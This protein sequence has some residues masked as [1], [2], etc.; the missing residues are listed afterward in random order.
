MAYKL[1]TRG[2]T[3]RG[4]SVGRTFGIAVEGLRLD[5]PVAPLSGVD[6]VGYFPPRDDLSGG[7]ILITRWDVRRR[8]I[9]ILERVT[10]PAG[11]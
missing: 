4:Q 10:A 2:R 7:A 1:A 5:V 6:P 11:R 3:S 8:V 9:A